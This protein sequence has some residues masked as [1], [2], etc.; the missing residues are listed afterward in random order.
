MKTKNIE[1]RTKIFLAM[2]SGKLPEHELNKLYQFLWENRYFWQSASTHYHGSYPGGLFDHSLAVTR[3]LVQ[4][5]Q[6]NHLSWSREASPILI[7]FLHDICKMDAYL[8]QK[9]PKTGKITYLWNKG[10]TDTGHGSKSV[11]LIMPVI[12]MFDD[13]LACIEWHMGAYMGKDYYAPLALAIKQ[14]PN[15]LFAH[16][17][18]MMAS[19]LQNT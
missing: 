1:E 8:P 18:D 4:L 12:P 15:I 19:T 10:Q 13:E 14:T 7:G 2:L 3:N 5:T 11:R 16:M 6:D 17:A 9:D